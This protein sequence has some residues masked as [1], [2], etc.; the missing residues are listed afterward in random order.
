MNAAVAYGQGQVAA[1]VRQLAGSH[2]N[3]GYSRVDVCFDLGGCEQKMMT[4][5]NRNAKKPTDDDE[6]GFGVAVAGSK[7]GRHLASVFSCR[8]SGR[9]E[10]LAEFGNILADLKKVTVELGSPDAPAV[11]AFS[12][13]GTSADERSRTTAVVLG[14]DGA[15]TKTDDGSS[16]QAEDT[17]LVRLA[18]R[19][20]ATAGK[21]AVIH[22]E[23]TDLLLIGVLAMAKLMAL[24]TNQ[25]FTEDNVMRMK[26]QAVE[27]NGVSFSEEYMSCGALARS[28]VQHPGLQHIGDE[29]MRVASVV[30]ALVL[31]GGD[32]TS[33]MYIPYRKGLPWYLENVKVIGSLVR[34]ATTAEIEEGCTLVLDQSAVETFIMAMYISRD[35]ASVKPCW[36][37][38]TQDQRKGALGS[39]VEIQKLVAR[40]K[41]PRTT[42]FMP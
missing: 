23:D 6:V 28:I 38:M 18:L 9:R 3:A 2:L 8:R 37:G 32:T 22:A 19:C 13:V 7:V 16:S 31:L 27:A 34:R 11:A 42:H 12:G 24:C 26:K 36:G 29:F 4:E 20:S 41:V 15:W 21:V 30:S 40:A 25:E 17:N 39:Y 10:F 14:E 1:V 33:Y 35:E 5:K